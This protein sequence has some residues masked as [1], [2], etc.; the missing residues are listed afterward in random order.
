MDTE[1]KYYKQYDL[2]DP[3]KKDLHIHIY[4]LGSIG[5]H[6]AMALAKMGV[7]TLFLYDYD[8]VEEDN[9]P[10]Q[11]YGKDDIGKPK[12]EALKDKINTETG[13]K[14]AIKEA[15]IDKYFIPDTTPDSIHIVAFDNIESRK[16]IAQTLKHFS[17]Y[18]IDGRIGGF[19]AEKYAVWCNYTEDM[20]QYLQTLEGEFGELKCGEKCLYPVNALIASLITSDVIRIYQ[21]K[22]PKAIVKTNLMGEATISREKW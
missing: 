18:L 10:A 1:T 11:L 7:A 8:T 12:L 5:S 9:T 15:V 19:Q 14:P 21:D 4:G 13:V 16:A 3:S 20:D 22:E 6:T 2:F 17:V